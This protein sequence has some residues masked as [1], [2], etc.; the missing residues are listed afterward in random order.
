MLRV[1][2]NNF[3]FRRFERYDIES[4]L[5]ALA[6]SFSFEIANPK[7]IH[8]GQILPGKVVQLFDDNTPLMI[9]EIDDVEESDVIKV[10]GRD[11]MVRAIENDV[12][13]EEEEDEIE[14]DK[15]I[16]RLAKLVGIKKFDLS[17]LTS[18][19]KPVENISTHRPGAKAPSRVKA[20]QE[21]TREAGESVGEV[22]V[23]LADAGNFY[24]WLDRLGVLHLSFYNF[25]QPAGWDFF[26]RLNGANCDLIKRR[27]SYA[28]LKG[29]IWAYGDFFVL[30]PLAANIQGFAK[31]E[32]QALIR[33][34]FTRRKT[35]LDNYS[36]TYEEASAR[37]EKLMNELKLRAK[38]WEVTYGGPHARGGAIPEPGKTA[39]LTS[40][41]S[42]VSNLKVLIASVNLKKTD[43]GTKTTLILR[44]KP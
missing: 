1:K 31:K 21:F 41:Y 4:S 18:P 6:D 23:R 28:N 26:N 32:D 34:G 19:I 12:E 3:E 38:Q 39:T 36:L 43:E 42:A 17:G 20:L 24:I 13:H 25:S 30:G 35:M 14:P 10:T 8:A 33:A 22:M 29:S 5:D 7:G 16:I 2:T 44:E 15:E 9:G 27:Q 11:L 37:L 40:I